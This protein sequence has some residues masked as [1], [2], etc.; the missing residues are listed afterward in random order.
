M[1]KITS[2]FIRLPTAARN[3][4]I[5]TATYFYRNC[6]DYCRDFLK[7]ILGEGAKDAAQVLPNSLPESTQSPAITVVFNTL[8]TEIQS[9]YFKIIK[10]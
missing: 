9:K 5:L 4:K 6:S 10:L 1:I 7:R 3:L 2:L 8:T